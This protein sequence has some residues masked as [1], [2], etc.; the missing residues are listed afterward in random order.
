MVIHTG[1][2]KKYSLIS[3]TTPSLKEIGSYM[4]KHKPVLNRFI[5]KL[6]KQ[7]SLPWILI[8]QKTKNPKETMIFNKQ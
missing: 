3:I 5:L 1:T 8:I 2:K 6:L 7:N 4:Y